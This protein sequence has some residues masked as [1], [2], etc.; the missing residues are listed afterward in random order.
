MADKCMAKYF[1][2]TK[3]SISRVLFVVQEI[4]KVQ[5]AVVFAMYPFHFL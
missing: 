3:Y 5:E 2:V 4:L 1:L